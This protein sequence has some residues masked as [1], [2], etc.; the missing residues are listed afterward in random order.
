MICC[1]LPCKVL[2]NLRL[3]FHGRQYFFSKIDKHKFAQG[4]SRYN[5]KDVYKYEPAAAKIFRSPDCCFLRNHDGA[6]IFPRSFS[7]LNYVHPGLQ[8][9]SRKQN[10]ETHPRQR[11][12]AETEANGSSV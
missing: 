7:R 12:K 3:R 4:Y 5:K 9:D 8:K 2:Y 10:A 1:L 6:N 11:H